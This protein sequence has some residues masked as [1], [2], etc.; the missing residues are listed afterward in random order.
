MVSSK[1]EAPLPLSPP[2]R[3][4]GIPHVPLLQ[5]YILKYLIPSSSFIQLQNVPIQYTSKK[6]VKM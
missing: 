2:P 3:T 6:Q 4:R 1:A 5:Y